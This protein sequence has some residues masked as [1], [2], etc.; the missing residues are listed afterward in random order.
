MKESVVITEE[1]KKEFSTTRIDKGVQRV[2]NESEMRLGSLRG[3]I[4]SIRCDG[5]TPSAESIAT[6]ISSMH[7][8][9]RT[10]ALLALQCT[11][12]NWYV[13]RVVA[14]IQAKLKVGQLG[15]IY[16]Q[17]VDRVAEPSGVRKGAMGDQMRTILRLPVA[18]SFLT[19][20]QEE[21][22][23]P[24]TQSWQRLSPAERW[25]LIC[26]T[27]LIG[28]GALAEAMTNEA[29]RQLDKYLEKII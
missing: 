13:Q 2:Q 4:G 28:A 18:S 15:D 20:L 11:H 10:P 24:M 3:V 6:H 23:N 26:Q 29:S 27:V 25:L 22:A 9:E 17:E 16:E 14:G 5:G 1:E 7:T 19:G 8:T 21:V 12:S